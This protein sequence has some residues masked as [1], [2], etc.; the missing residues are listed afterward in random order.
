[1]IPA[2][3]SASE[4]LTSAH[5]VVRSTCVAMSSGIPNALCDHPV[6]TEREVSRLSSA[7]GEGRLTLTS[8]ET[9]ERDS[10][11]NEKFGAS[12]E[13]DKEFR[14]IVGK[15]VDLVAVL[16]LESIGVLLRGLD[17][18]EIVLKFDFLRVS[19]LLRIVAAK[20]LRFCADLSV[21]LERRYDTTYRSIEYRCERECAFRTQP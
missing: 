10:F 16:S 3:R 7:R 5:S 8:D 18:L 20:E 1:M 9:I 2:M 13:L 11:R 17:R 14:S 6:G 15:D 12:H 19:L 4:T 21:M